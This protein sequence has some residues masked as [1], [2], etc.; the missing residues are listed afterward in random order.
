VKHP[1]VQLRALRSGFSSA[2]RHVGPLF[3]YL[4]SPGLTQQR[5]CIGSSPFTWEIVFEKSSEWWLRITWIVEN[6]IQHTCCGIYLVNGCLY[7]QQQ[8]T[9]QLAAIKHLCTQLDLEI[10]STCVSRRLVQRI[11]IVDPACINRVHVNTSFL[12]L[13]CTCARHHVQSRLCPAYPTTS[14]IASTKA[15]HQDSNNNI[16]RA[17]H[18]RVW[19]VGRLVAIKLA[20]HRR[21]VD[22]VFV[23]SRPQ[24]WGS[25]HHGYQLAIYNKRC[26]RVDGECFSKFRGFNI[27]CLD[28]PHLTQ[29]RL[30]LHA[31]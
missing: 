30:L 22:D 19:M 21:H 29:A 3:C 7:S 15:N 23:L 31:Q 14:A 28:T 9:S 17:L 13:L 4:C 1:C 18:V 6:G 10:G 12:Q 25:Y 5:H 27:V 11:F 20:L 16:T 8:H 2:Q 24:R 26:Q